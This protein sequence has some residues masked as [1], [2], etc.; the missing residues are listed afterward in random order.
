MSQ[1]EPDPNTPAPPWVRYGTS[2]EHEVIIGSPAGLQKLRDHIGKAI[3][4]GESIISE[5]DMWFSG[6]RCKASPEDEPT[7]GG[8][9]LATWGCLLLVA[10]VLF[11]ALYGGWTLIT[12]Y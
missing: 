3:S 11:L 8:S 4:D 10:T 12:K 5:T 9:S 2:S 6:V 1:S 7:D